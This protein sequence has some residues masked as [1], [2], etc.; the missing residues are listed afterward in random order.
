MGRILEAFARDELHAIPIDE[1]RNPK[2][3]KLCDKA[4]ELMEKLEEKLNNKDKELLNELM[5][6]I[7][8]EN[9]C[10]AQSRF[11]RGY[12]LG[13]LMTMEVMSEQETFFD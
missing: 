12:S 3:Q 10:Y 6:V 1:I 4:C 2:H 5:D 11:I 9:C 8:N 13:V 7:A